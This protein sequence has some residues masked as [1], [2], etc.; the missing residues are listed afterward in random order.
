MPNTCPNWPTHAPTG[1]LMSI[2]GPSNIVQGPVGQ[3]VSSCSDRIIMTWCFKECGTFVHGQGDFSSLGS[4][5]RRTTW[6]GVFKKCGTFVHGQ[7]VFSSLG[8]MQNYPRAIFQVSV[9]CKITPSSGQKFSFFLTSLSACVD[10]SLVRL[11]READNFDRRQLLSR[12][13]AGSRLISVYVFNIIFGLCSYPLKGRP[14]QTESSQRNKTHNFL[15]HGRCTAQRG[16]GFQSELRAFWILKHMIFEMLR[17][18]SV[19]TERVLFHKKYNFLIARQS[20]RFGWLDF[21]FGPEI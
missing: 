11:N 19:R 15:H 5:A 16:Q 20:F 1:A 14:V 7:G 6:H 4:L 3:T 21:R 13:L 17:R 18:C 2:Q 10:P 12:A 8:Q 9:K